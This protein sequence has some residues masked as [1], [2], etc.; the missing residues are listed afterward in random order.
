LL[1][2][3]PCASRTSCWRTAS[4]FAPR[5]KRESGTVDA[6][7]R[8]IAGVATRP[9]EAGMQGWNSEDQPTITPVSTKKVTTAAV[10]MIASRAPIAVG[11]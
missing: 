2:R 6:R 10:Q 4:D 5:T 1:A 9:T 3:G 7:L 11:S 8:P